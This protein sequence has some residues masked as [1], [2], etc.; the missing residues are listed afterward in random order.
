MEKQKKRYIEERISLRHRSK[1]NHIKA[2]LR[3]GKHNKESVQEA[4]K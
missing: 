1:N 2:L 3:F 4:L